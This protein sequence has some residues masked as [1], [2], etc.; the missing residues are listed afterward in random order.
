MQ[1]EVLHGATGGR[2]D[3]AAADR[4]AADRIEVATVLAQPPAGFRR[5]SQRSAGKIADPCRLACLNG[6]AD[7]WRLAVAGHAHAEYLAIGPDRDQQPDL[8]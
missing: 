4:C 7:A 6:V 1:A 2:D 5:I 8:A 3:S